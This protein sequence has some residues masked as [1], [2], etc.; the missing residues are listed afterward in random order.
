M[1]IEHDRLQSLVAS[2]FAAAGC[3]PTEAEQ[4]AKYLVASNLVGHDSH[5]VIRVPAYISWLREGKVVANQSPRI[6]FENEALAVIDGQRHAAQNMR[7]AAEGIYGLD[8]EQHLNALSNLKPTAARR[9]GCWRRRC[10]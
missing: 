10:R 3:G 1:R 9:E 4:V 7:R 5:G 8:L 2:L 6:V